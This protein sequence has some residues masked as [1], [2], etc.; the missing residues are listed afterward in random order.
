M[1]SHEEFLELQALAGGLISRAVETKVFTVV[2][3]ID[4]IENRMMMASSHKGDDFYAAVK[5]A[6]KAFEVSEGQGIVTEHKIPQSPD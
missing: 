3:A 1:A 2:M 5:L 4:P 6:V